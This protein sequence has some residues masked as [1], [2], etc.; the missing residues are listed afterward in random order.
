MLRQTFGSFENPVF[1]VYWAGM[2]GSS[3]AMQMQQIA[4]GFLAYEISGSAVALGVVTLAWGAPML[5]LSPIG[6]VVADRMSKRNLVIASQAVLGV[7]TVINAV[8][9]SAG[10]IEVWHLVV[11]GLVQGG[12]FAFN[13]PARQ[14]LVP[15]LAGPAHLANAVALSNAGTNLTRVLGPTAAGLLIA[16]PAVG[17]AGVFYLVAACHVV[18]VLTLFRVPVSTRPPAGPRAGMLAEITVGMRYIW[19]D[20]ALRT[21]MGLAFIPVLLAMP[22]QSL[23]PVFAKQAFGVG[24]E[25]LG[26]LMGTA[27]LGALGGSLLVAF[28][29]ASPHKGR[30]QIAA[31]V[32]F[33]CALVAL[34]AA[35]VFSLGVLACVAVGAANHMY[36]ALNNTIILSSCEPKMHG[37]VMSVYLMTFSLMPLTT[38]PMSAATDVAGARLTIGVAGALTA[39]II[40]AAALAVPAVRAR[41][42]EAARAQG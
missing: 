17:T 40:A 21:L 9:I 13:L 4:R 5:I 23:M 38:M 25:G 10:I 35:P 42:T 3:L 41:T 31:G 2:L 16:I 18:V 19:G 32:L 33:G 39:A 26:L 37:R 22:Y 29:S 34:A 30:L 1:R 6:G 7:A 12:T 20:P 27:G 8:L 15:E 36:L 11:L 24:S 28:F 14:A